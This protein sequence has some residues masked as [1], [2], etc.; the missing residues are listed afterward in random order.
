[1][2]LRVQEHNIDTGYIQE[3]QEQDIFWINIDSPDSSMRTGRVNKQC[4]DR[5][6]QRTQQA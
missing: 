6:N 3:A 1:M 2:L 5:E 4:Q